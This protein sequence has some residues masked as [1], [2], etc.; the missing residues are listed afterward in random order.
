MIIGA[1]VATR[2]T[3]AGVGIEVC[4]TSVA[5]NTVAVRVSAVAAGKCTGS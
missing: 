2:A 5:V 4:L 3:V 1:A